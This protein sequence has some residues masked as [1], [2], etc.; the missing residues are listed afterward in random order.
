MEKVL[1]QDLE[2]LGFFGALQLFLWLRLNHYAF[3]NLN[4]LI[5]QIPLKYLFWYYDENKKDTASRNYSSP[6]L[7][8]IM[9]FLWFQLPLVNLSSY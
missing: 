6:P 9:G 1:G 2:K 8:V 4:F 3:L 7:L 5:Y